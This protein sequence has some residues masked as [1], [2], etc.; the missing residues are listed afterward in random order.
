MTIKYFSKRF[1]ITGATRGIGRAVVDGVRKAGGI[2]YGLGSNKELLDKLVEECPDVTPV[3]VDLSDWDSSRKELE[4][5]PAMDGIVNNAGYAAHWVASLD[6]PKELIDKTLNINLM[7]AINVIQVLGK[8][9]VEAGNGGSIVNISSVNGI[10]SMRECMAYNV[11]KAA[12]DMVTKQYALELGPYNI[13]VNSVN[14]TVILTDM[15]REHWGDPK[16]GVKLINATPLGRF[17]KVHEA[18][19]PILYLLSDYSSMVTGTINP[20]DGGLLSNNHV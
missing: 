3:H 17:C 5:L 10:K 20:V 9:M 12:L 15:G 6:A 7:G 11:S 18:V 19:N 16:K 14:P 8:K 1:F 2:V 4:K 13:R